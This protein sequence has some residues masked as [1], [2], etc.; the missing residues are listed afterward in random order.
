MIG[1][2]LKMALIN[3]GLILSFSGSPSPPE[4]Q[5]L[6]ERAKAVNQAVFQLKE[7]VSRVAAI[8]PGELVK[9]RGSEYSLGVTVAFRDQDFLRAQAMADLA[10]KYT[11]DISPAER[12]R[13]NYY[14]IRAYRDLGEESRGYLLLQ[15]LLGEKKISGLP[16]DLQV[17]YLE[18]L[19]NQGDYQTFEWIYRKMYTSIKSEDQSFYRWGKKLLQD[20]MAPLAL[21]TLSG[22]R[23]GSPYFSR[24]LYLRALAQV[25]SGDLFEALSLFT[26][27]QQLATRNGE[28]ALVDLALL[29]Q[30]RIGIFLEKSREV[31]SKYAAIPSDSAY[32]SE[33]QYELFLFAFRRQNYP[34]SLRIARTL[35]LK[36]PL[37]PDSSKFRLGE[38]YSLLGLGNSGEAIRILEA[39]K[40]RG[41]EFENQSGNLSRIMRQEIT[42]TSGI[43]EL[44]VLS[45]FDRA[46]KMAEGEFR[47]SKI[48]SRGDELD[49]EFERVLSLWEEVVL[50]L[51]P[52][53][54]PGQAENEIC[55]LNRIQEDLGNLDQEMFALSLGSLTDQARKN[56]QAKSTLTQAP[57]I[58]SQVQTLSSSGEADISGLIETI[59]KEEAKGKLRLEW[60][61]SVR[62]E[63]KLQNGTQPKKE[64][65]KL[66]ECWG[67]VLEAETG[68]VALQKKLVARET[69][70]FLKF[71]PLIKRIA[72]VLANL[73]ARKDESRRQGKD[74]LQA[75]K[76]MQAQAEIDK[77]KDILAQ[78]L[79]VLK[80]VP[81]EPVGSPASPPVINPGGKPAQKETGPARAGTVSPSGKTTTPAPAPGADLAAK[82]RLKDRLVKLEPNLLVKV[83]RTLD[84]DPLELDNNA[85]AGN[86]SIP[87]DLPIPKVIN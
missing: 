84:A 36:Y 17:F 31:G 46:R 27:C 33:A 43:R 1:L 60:I 78:A 20:K 3:A 48:D 52:G 70:N 42:E 13:I 15:S 26:Q 82:L 24:S 87:S 37:D 23:T 55:R 2:G 12:D 81:R 8:S 41:Q 47:E 53:C 11:A 61:K 75:L 32:Y 29:A 51:L 72:L 5:A 6:E 49:R 39:L 77:E 68:F 76:E 85:P 38:A 67:L 80:E 10:E 66:D 35:V 16:P 69:K 59:Q 14:R 65:E 34:E 73:E 64:W 86:A 71:N 58:Q 18:Q 54:V 74:I 45:L 30:A 83:L 50:K 79:A 7:E 57:G 4:I 40:A 21:L 25:Q 28:K 63:L 22:I 9:M 44:A 56:L 19:L 62:K